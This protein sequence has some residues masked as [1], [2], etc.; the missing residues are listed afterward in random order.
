[1]IETLF[2]GDELPAV[3][4]FESW[5][6]MAFESH[7]PHDIRT[8]HA[9]DFH[10]TL[11]VLDL[12]TVQVSVFSCPPL[13]SV[14]TP[15]LIRQSDPEIYH[16]SLPLSGRMGIVQDDQEILVGHGDLV[17]VSSS[18][19][20]R[21]R[22]DAADGTVSA[23][24]MVI[25]RALLPLPGGLAGRQF[26]MRLP[27]RTGMGALLAQFLTGLLTDTTPY[28][29][30]DSARLGGIAL[31]LATALLAHQRGTQ[32]PPETFQH[33]LAM[34]VRGYIHQHLADPELTPERIAAAQHI[35][36]RSLHRL[37]RHQN[38]TVSAYIR[39]QR[40]EQARR[41]LADPALR[42]RP[43]HA[44]AARWGFPR[45]ADFT[46]AFRAAYGMPPKD[47]R[48]LAQGAPSGLRPGDVPAQR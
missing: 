13:D 2:R 19:P 6:E 38:A 42:T 28:G 20:Y 30:S 46:R 8:E 25:P 27:G 29:P 35:S 16:L 5:R 31:D 10:G 36:V 14:R 45:P 34:R 37:F 12:G 41:Q 43:I 33:A 9:A 39:H 18:R 40:L 44:I 23:A 32:G 11:R 24:E 48:H 17:L 7:S 47:F 26:V 3:E 4:R 1:M 15:A 21:G 22:L